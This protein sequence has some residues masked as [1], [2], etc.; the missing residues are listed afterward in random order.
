MNKLE[1]WIKA[2]SNKAKFAREL[3]ISRLHLYRIISNASHPSR[4]LAKKIEQHTNGFV[5]KEELMWPEDYQ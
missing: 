1:V 5:K 4:E 2:Y 3:G